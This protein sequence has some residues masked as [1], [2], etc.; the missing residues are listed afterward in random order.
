MDGPRESTVVQALLRPP[1]FLGVPRVFLTMEMAIL[2]FVWFGAR[3]HWI[4]VLVTAVFVLLHPV[5]AWKCRENPW[6]VDM[7]RGYILRPVTYSN[8]T[9]LR[10]APRRPSRSLP[11]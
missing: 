5:V 9:M 2:A 1:L 3:F 8:R 7:F 6:A 4:S 11:R 10:A